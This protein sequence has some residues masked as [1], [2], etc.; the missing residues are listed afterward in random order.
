MFRKKSGLKNFTYS[1]IW[2]EHALS[3][4]RG[5]FAIDPIENITIGQEAKVSNSN[6]RDKNRYRYTVIYEVDNFECRLVLGEVDDEAKTAKVITIL[7]R[8]AKGIEGIK[9]LF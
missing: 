3:R 7:P 4:L 6:G 1:L 9:D 8:F 2:T 5:R